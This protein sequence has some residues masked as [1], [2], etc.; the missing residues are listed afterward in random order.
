MTG[1]DQII[2]ITGRGKSAI[3]DHFEISYELEK[4]RYTVKLWLKAGSVSKFGELLC[5]K[6]CA[7]FVASSRD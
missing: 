6:S 1:Y 2:I 4:M 5:G 7:C 3:E